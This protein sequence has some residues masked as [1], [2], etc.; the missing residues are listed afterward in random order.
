MT[1]SSAGWTRR[2]FLSLVG[3]VGGAAAV[4]E[5]MTALGWMRMP[6]AWAGPPK[7]E[8][9]S[10]R[11]RKVLIL[12]AGIGGLTAAYE[13]TK[14]GYECLILEAQDR[15]G[16][17]S[18]TARR[19]S[20]IT[21]QSPEN[22]VTQQHCQF[23]DG[24]YLNM[25]PGRLPYHHR[26]VLHYCHELGVP[27][28]IYVMSTTANLFQTQDAFGGK[29]M[30]RRR[31][32]TDAQGYISELLAKQVCKGS[33]DQELTP[34]E[35][36]D[37]LELLNVFGDLDATGSECYEKDPACGRSGGYE[38]CGSTRAGCATLTIYEACTAS[39]PI[40]LKTLLQSRFW[41]ITGDASFY[42]PLEF[43]WQPTL[44]QPVGGMDQIVEGFKRQIGQLISYRSEARAIRISDGGV[45]VDYVDRFSG[46]H[47]SARADWCLSNIPLP[48]LQGI[49]ANFSSGFKDAVDHGK[50]APTCKVGWQANRRFWESDRYQ[51]YGGIS[52]VDD[53]ITQM[54]YPSNGWFTA[55]G[56]LT[57]AYNYSNHALALGRMKLADRL[58]LARE[59]G[60]RL[61][62]EIGDPAIV[63]EDLGL[64]I[65]W[66]NV[67]FQRGGWADWKPEDDEYYERL[68]APDGRFH[69]VGD[70]VSTLPGWQ[71]G[72]MMSAE[73]V[74]EQIA[75]IRPL[76][77]PDVK[78]APNTRRLV[79]GLR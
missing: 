77:G 24:L 21:E 32:E 41:D 19:G 26:R 49:P 39:Q 66:Q 16:G 8:K 29:V 7:L 31:L 4:H 74:V 59:Q 75:G 40:P 78:Q 25:G 18:L 71:E 43:E 58:R 47:C 34:A 50:F 56:T 27:L 2:S 42:Q 12:G 57:G 48:L 54:W 35:R 30:L 44:F 9:G 68:L 36:R 6:E 79:Q 11:G 60:A 69:I 22:G 23:D 38:Y 1:D 45:E 14:A 37:L 62:P 64:S 73:H 10:G 15:A 53:T 72:A 67:P 55:N 46:Q 3:R 13:L 20:T 65:A 70:Q 52:Y 28:E 61:H 76:T 63:P 17:R 5:T 51:I 33:L